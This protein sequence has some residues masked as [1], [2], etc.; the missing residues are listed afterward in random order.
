MEKDYKLTD[1]KEIWTKFCF[2][3]ESG[4]LSNPTDVL[5]TIGIIKCSQPYFLQS[6]I[7]YER[8]KRNFHDEIK[9]NKLSKNNFEF[10]KYMLDCLF[11]TGSLNFY[12]YT[13][14]KKGEYF[15]NHF[16]NNI[17]KAYEDITIRLVGAAL[18]NNEVLI[19]IADHVTVPRNIRFE[20]N[21]KR[22]INEKYSRLAMA[23]VCRFDSKSNDL[24]QLTD[25]I[26]GAINYDLKFSLGIIKK[27]DKYKKRFLAYLKKNLGID[28][29][30]FLSKGFKNYIFNVFVD[31]DL[32]KEKI[33]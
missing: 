2:L 13:V 14:D 16:G 17:W 20:C 7:H 6:K 9:F 8:D 22:K 5:F 29:E 30:E 15:M 28:K 23:G 11:A 32:K 21:V 12:S 26:V 18:P 24:L 1:Y 31:P 4:S 3:D 33:V 19:L 25:L 27:G 10:A